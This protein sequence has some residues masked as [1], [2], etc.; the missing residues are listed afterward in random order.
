[1]KY[2]VITDNGLVQSNT[3][4]GI[5]QKLKAKLEDKEFKQLGNDKIVKITDRD[6]EFIQDKKRLSMIPIRNLYKKN[7]TT[8]LLLVVVLVLQFILLIK[9]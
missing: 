9:K 1:M 8:M 2:S 7:N 6:L 3:L 5:N 4:L